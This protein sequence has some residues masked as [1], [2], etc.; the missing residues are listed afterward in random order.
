MDRLHLF[1]P[2]WLMRWYIVTLVLVH[3][4][5]IGRLPGPP[6]RCPAFQ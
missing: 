5:K 6:R 1:Q 4:T 3:E 2:A